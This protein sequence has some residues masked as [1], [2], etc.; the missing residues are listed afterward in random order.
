MPVFVM[1]ASIWLSLEKTSPRKT[2][3]A[4]ICVAACVAFVIKRNWHRD[5]W[6]EYNY[7][8]VAQI[9]VPGVATIT[10]KRAVGASKG[11]LFNIGFWF[12]IIGV[13]GELF[14]YS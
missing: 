8:Y 10:T 14:Y 7:W 13:L 1:V 12:T 3:G 6:F 9:I 5:D 2:A 11:G 4:I